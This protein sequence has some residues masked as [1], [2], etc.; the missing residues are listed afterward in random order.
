MTFYDGSTSLGTGPVSAGTATLNVPGGFGVGDHPLTASAAATDTTSSSIS[1]IVDVMIG[2]STST[3][4]LTLTNPTTAYGQHATGTVAVSNATDGT[5]TVTVA[6]TNVAVAIGADGTG[7]FTLPNTLS[8]GHHTVSAVYNG[9][10]T[11]EPS[12]PVS[13]TLTVI[14]ALT[15]TTLALS[16][17]TVHRGGK[18][19]VTVT[20]G[21]DPSPFYPAGTVTV[22]VTGGGATTTPKAHLSAGEHGVVTVTITLP[23]H[24]GTADVYAV[25]SGSAQF[26]TSTSTTKTVHVT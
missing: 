22:H 10:A 3:I 7:G 18:E 5:A 26:K 9:S 23:S 11:V 4:V 17:T 8:I 16:A 19:S 24:P 15:T 13:T 6:S 12:G 2:K 21:R 25:Y 14:P 20:V 1:P